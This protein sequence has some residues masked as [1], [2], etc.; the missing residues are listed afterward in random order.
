MGKQDASQNAASDIFLKTLAALPTH[1]ELGRCRHWLFVIAHN[2][3][4]DTVR[5]R[6]MHG[7]LETA[8]GIDEPDIYPRNRSSRLS[9][10]IGSIR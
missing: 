10:G 4:Q 9:I 7:S 1:R 8:A 6:R 5:A 2:A 3:M